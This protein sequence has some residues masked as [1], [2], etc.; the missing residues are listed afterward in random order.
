MYVARR[1]YYASYSS[2]LAAPPSGP[3]PDGPTAERGRR[4]FLTISNRVLG[5]G[6]GTRFWRRA[7]ERHFTLGLLG[8]RCGVASLRASLGLLGP[9]GAARPRCLPHCGRSLPQKHDTIIPSPSLFPAVTLDCAWPVRAQDREGH[10]AARS[11][12]RSWTGRTWSVTW[13]FWGFFAPPANRAE[14]GE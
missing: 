2:T 12:A 7:L 4:P 5:H 3:S 11:M 13:I 14:R 6:F 8:P 1:S 9:R 10:S